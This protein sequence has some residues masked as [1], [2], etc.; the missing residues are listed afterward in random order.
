MPFSVIAAPCLASATRSSLTSRPPRPT[1]ASASASF[2]G[3]GPSGSGA[4][5]R[6][7]IRIKLPQ[8]LH[9]RIERAVGQIGKM[10]RGL[11]QRDHVG[12]GRN[13]NAAAVEGADRGVGLVQA[14]LLL[15]PPH[16]QE[17]PLDKPL[18]LGPVG[19][20]DL[21]RHLRAER[22]SAPAHGIA[23]PRSSAT[24]Q[25]CRPAAVAA[26]AIMRRRVR[27]RLSIGRPRQLSRTSG[28]SLWSPAVSLPST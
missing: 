2:C 15:Q 20:M 3:D 4:F 12:V 23:R 7:M 26:M 9:R 5:R 16:V 6:E 25:K 21:D 13:K 11:Q 14:E 22:R 27:F 18:G 1:F 17:A 24:G 28:C 19:M 10:Q 8:R